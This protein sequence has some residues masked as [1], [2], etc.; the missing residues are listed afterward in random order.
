MTGRTK[1]QVE[2]QE[3]DNGGEQCV[4][5]C[6]YRPRSCGRYLLAGQN[7]YVKMY[8]TCIEVQ[9]KEPLVEG[10]ASEG[11]SQVGC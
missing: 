3:H 8:C 4:S 5:A 1:T 10:E 7:V 6:R 2:H 9:G 11:L